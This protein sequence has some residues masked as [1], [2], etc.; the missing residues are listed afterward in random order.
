MLPA[1]RL[2]LMPAA[3]RTRACGQFTL[4]VFFDLIVML[5]LMLDLIQSGQAGTV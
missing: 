1:R 5:D 4:G 2:M 3:T